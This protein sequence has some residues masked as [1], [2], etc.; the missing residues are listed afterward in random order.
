MSVPNLES[1]RRALRRHASAAHAIVSATFFKTGKGEYGEGDRFIGVTVPEIRAVAEAYRAL[2][3]NDVVRLLRSRIHEE[4]YVA[5]EMF[6]DRYRRGDVKTRNTIYRL[7]LANTR[8]INNWDLVDTSAP[9]I[10]GVH[11]F[12]HGVATLRRLAR[13]KN[14]WERRIAIIATFHFLRQGRGKETLVIARLLLHDQHDLI[15]KAVGWM[16]RELGKL[17]SRD[18]LKKFL[19]QY[20][21]RMPRTMLRYAIEHFSTKERQ[22][23]LRL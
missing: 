3:L 23:Y 12:P 5:L 11:L 20:A 14:L 6:V 22:K 8:W 19:D 16:L 1:V 7:Y 2:P 21:P 18:E 17:V 10:V 9:H 15:H 13:S 4:R